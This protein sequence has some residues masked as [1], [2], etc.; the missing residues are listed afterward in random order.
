MP[1]KSGRSSR[2]RCRRGRAGRRPGSVLPYT[3]VA[4]MA[5]LGV[6]S[7]ALD[8][9]YVQITKTE[10]QRCAAAT[11]HGYMQYYAMNGQAYADA[12]G[13]QLYAAG[14]NPVAAGSGVSPT[15]TV[16]WGQWVASSNTFNPG[17]GGGNTTAVKV[18]A[19]RSTANGNPIN[20]FWASIFGQQ[21][22]SVTATAIA[23]LSGGGQTSTVTIPSTANPYL[24]GMPAGSTGLYGDTTAN[25]GPLQVTTI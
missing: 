15:V 5:L 20:L 21:S 2:G 16:Q 1:D 14:Y 18:T 19:S 7:L 12:N 13:P 17:N 3:V 9:G 22:A 6:C 23:T 10:L 4:F 8:W 24:A 11:A 25:A